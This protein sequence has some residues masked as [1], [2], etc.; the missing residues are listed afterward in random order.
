[1]EVLG[2]ADDLLN[3]GGIKHWPD[4]LEALVMARAPVADAGVSAL[5]NADG[6]GEIYVGIVEP[7]CEDAALAGHIAEAL[8]TKLLGD[9]RIVKLERIP[10]NVNGKIQRKLLQKAVARARQTAPGGAR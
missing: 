7:R 2:R 6:M 1:L 8:R 5:P 4:D 9:I 3:I 10:R